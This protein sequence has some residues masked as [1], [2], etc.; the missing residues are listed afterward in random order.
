MKKL[1]TLFLAVILII[2][3]LPVYASAANEKDE[4]VLTG[5]VT[6]TQKLHMRSSPS[7]DA[8]VITD[9][10]SGATVEVL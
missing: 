5:T 10:K 6:G 7:T 2:Q 4:L 9:L 1:L 3:L 8:S